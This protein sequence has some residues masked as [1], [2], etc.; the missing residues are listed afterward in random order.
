MDNFKAKKN[1]KIGIYSNPIVILQFY[2]V[3]FLNCLDIQG[4]RGHLVIILFS[5]LITP[6][7][8]REPFGP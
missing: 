8:I 6:S 4:N 5:F 1:A 3:G 7:Y 2:D